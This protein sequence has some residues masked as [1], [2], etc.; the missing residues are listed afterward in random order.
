MGLFPTY[1]D[2]VARNTKLSFT[3]GHLSIPEEKIKT[4]GIKRIWGLQLRDT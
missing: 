3:S 1:V 4:R 2:F